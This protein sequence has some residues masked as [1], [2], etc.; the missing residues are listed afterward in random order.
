MG[1]IGVGAVRIIDGDGDAVDDGAGKLKTVEQAFTTWTTYQAFEV[2]TTATAINAAAPNGTGA[3]ITNA[4]EIMIQSDD[5]N[6]GGGEYIMI[7]NSAATCVTSGTITSR[8]G[9]ILNAGET[10]IIPMGAFSKVYLRA[11]AAD[12]VVYVA[13]FS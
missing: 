11:S 12:Q 7:G 4:N 5:S 2:P 13:Y 10:I 3:S 6:G 1:S 8:L 9:I